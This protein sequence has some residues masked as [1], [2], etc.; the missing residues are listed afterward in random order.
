MTT[1][2]ANLAAMERRLQNALPASLGHSDAKEE[3]RIYAE[4]ES[5]SRRYAA[6]AAA[7]DPEA[8]KRLVFLW[9]YAQA[10]PSHLSGVG[11]FPADL[12]QRVGESLTRAVR[13][14][15]DEEFRRMLV[16]YYTI[17]DWHF[18]ALVPTI[19]STLRPMVPLNRLA[20][21]ST[22][23]SP[24]DTDSERGLMGDYFRSMR[25]SQTRRESTM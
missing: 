4:Y 14:G 24:I 25:Y 15:I 23:L 5:I 20:D 13:A 6:L 9:W 11:E 3:H 12:S 22:D 19:A 7:G 10:E 17:T 1:E 2:L 16:W 18:E 8:L 21:G